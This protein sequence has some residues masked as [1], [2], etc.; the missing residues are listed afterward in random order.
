MKM[1]EE[2]FLPAGLGE[3][4]N[5]PVLSNRLCEACNNS[6]GNTLE[7]PFLRVGPIGLMRWI[8][9]IRGRKGNSPSPFAR[10]A[11]K[12]KPVVAIGH[13]EGFDFD[14]ALE[15]HPG[16]QDAGPMRQIVMKHPILGYRPFP[17]FDGMTKESFLA[18]L[19]E[20]GFRSAE[21][22][23]AFAS[24][25]ERSWISDLAS[26]LGSQVKPQWTR[27]NMTNERIEITA[28]FNDEAKTLSS[29]DRENRLSLPTNF[30]SIATR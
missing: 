1:S 23:H 11:A 9:G 3:Y 6:L 5:C 29:R 7:T 4:R 25:A 24:E 10:P 8:V 17:I 26:G 22:V 20:E 15:V 14:I 21:P 13:I 19:D 27:T 18:Q 16:T 12:T 2:H 28:T 30:L